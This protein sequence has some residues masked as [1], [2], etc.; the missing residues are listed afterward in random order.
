[1]ALTKEKQQIDEQERA[2]LVDDAKLRLKTAEL[3]KELAQRD[4]YTAAERIKMAREVD[5][6]EKANMKDDMDR[7]IRRHNNLVKQYNLEGK[8]YKDLTAEQKDALRKSEADIYNIKA[9]YSEKTKKVGAL[10]SRA[11][12]EILDEQQTA[13]QKAEQ[14][15]SQMAAAG[16]AQR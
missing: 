5:N 9:E 8:A 1:M 6:L 10:E 15:R 4:K 13:N 16:A 14:R 3:K 11:R 7:Q 2:D 12:Q